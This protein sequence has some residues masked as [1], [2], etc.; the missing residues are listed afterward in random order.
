M[1]AIIEAYGLTRRF[2]D[3]VAVD[4]VD[5]A[6]E[7]GEV[8]GFLGP[9]AAGKTTTVRML[10]GVLDPTE[11]KALV[12]GCDVV[13][14]PVRARE[15]CGIVPE[16]ANVYLDLSVWQNLMLMAEL[17]AVPRR[18]R[19]REGERLLDMF[20]LA[21]R[22]KDK[23][24]RLSKGL[25]QRLMLC[26]ALVSKPEVLFLDEPTS[27]LDV[28]SARLIR[29]MVRELNGIGL[30]VF[31][32]THNMDEAEEM[33]GRVAIID[34][35][36]IA[37]IDTP[38]GLRDAV[39]SSQWVEVTFAGEEGPDARVLEGVEGVTG[40]A[41]TGKTYSLQTT[42]PG[43]VATKVIRLAD[44]KGW[45][46]ETICTRKPTLEEVFLHITGETPGG[47]SEGP[48]RQKRKGGPG[49]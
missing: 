28:A 23:A 30:T 27:G 36:K 41:V 46:V 24:R 14:E 20:G 42:A 17:H 7:E 18:D 39:R 26:T 9:N 40:C 21:Q 44:E 16:E 22:R 11:G 12:R 1:S 38:D 49:E 47:P 15:R 19:V 32:T 37:A 2:G 6:V 31:L 13:R 35:G 29:D 34:R 8:F 33:C 5:F 10:T 48:G 4:H 45:A 43:D 3:V 25:R